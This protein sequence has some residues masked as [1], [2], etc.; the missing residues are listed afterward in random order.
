MRIHGQK[1]ASANSK[2][3]TGKGQRL[4]SLLPL[5]SI[6]I[7]EDLV[8]CFVY[9]YHARP[10][11]TSSVVHVDVSRR[12][13]HCSEA[14]EI[15]SDQV[16]KPKKTARRTLQHWARLHLVC[17]ANAHVAVTGLLRHNFVALGLLLVLC[18][19]LDAP[20]ELILRL[21]RLNRLELA[22]KPEAQGTSVLL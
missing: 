15:C 14:L 5:E 13:I 2:E 21:T 10:F 8:L 7:R 20:I 6:V 12:I 16:Q 17:L 18:C 1:A 22:K 3:E 9:Q 11:R 19:D 4:Q